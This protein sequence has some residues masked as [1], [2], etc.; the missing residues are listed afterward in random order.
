V[1]TGRVRVTVEGPRWNF[2]GIARAFGHELTRPVVIRLT[3]FLAFL[4]VWTLIVEWTGTDLVP[5][6]SEVAREMVELAREGDVF[7]PFA[8]SLRRLAAGF[9]ITVA[10]GTVVGVAVG[11]FR[12]VDAFLHDFLVAGVTFPYLITALLVAM[13]FGYG[14]RGPVIVLVVTA[15]PFVA[16]NVAEGVKCVDRDL[17]DMARSYDTSW[18]RTI[19]HV[20]LPS[21]SPFFF[22]SLRFGLSIGWRALI[23]AEVFAATSGA[24]YEMAEIWERGNAAGLIAFGMYFIIFALL[25]DRVFAAVSRRVFRWRPTT[26]RS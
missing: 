2:A 24:G 4:G 13:W 12:H 16:I 11:V 7:S 23:L 9:V 1:E 15:L 17:V 6:P 26:E 8:V 22:A 21:V 19:R 14:D 3:A 10:L 18:Y 20:V 5:L 25:M